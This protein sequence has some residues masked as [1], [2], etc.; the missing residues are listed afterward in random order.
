[1]N[2][3]VL[4]LVTL[5]NNSDTPTPR[6]V[7]VI[8]TT[9]P[10][11]WLPHFVDQVGN[12]LFVEDQAE[13]A[14][15]IL[16]EHPVGVLMADYRALKDGWTGPR[17]ASEVARRPELRGV[18]VWL[19]AD[20]WTAE[21]AQLAA[22]CGA[23]G[24]L[25]RTVQAVRARAFGA[26]ITPD[27]AVAPQAPELSLNEQDAQWKQSVDWMF[28]RFVGP[29]GAFMIKQATQRMQA[30]QPWSQEAYADALANCV[31]NPAR[32]AEFLQALR[33]QGCL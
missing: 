7:A 15:R 21:D 13:A 30:G 4:K 10:E 3:R 6:R 11:L 14:L 17:L 26:A 31:L 18:S 29:M 2:R 28:R 23:Q 25:P 9:Q 32:R 27:A 16:G 22:Q 12:T 33:E 20:R 8:A 24:M 1:M 5:S 19:L